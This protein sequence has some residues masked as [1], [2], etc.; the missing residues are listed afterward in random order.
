MESTFK[1]PL[2]RIRI[3]EEVMGPTESS[4]FVEIEILAPE[5]QMIEN[6]DSFF[7]ACRNFAGACRAILKHEGANSMSGETLQSEC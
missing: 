7:I 4:L 2:N 6:V 1:I 5:S 3:P